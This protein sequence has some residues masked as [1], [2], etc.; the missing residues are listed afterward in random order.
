MGPIERAQRSAVDTGM[1][2]QL[3][4]IESLRAAGRAR[5]GP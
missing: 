4:E 5:A 3:A 1:A 2:T